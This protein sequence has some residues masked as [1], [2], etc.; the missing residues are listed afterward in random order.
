MLVR[1]SA[2]AAAGRVIDQL[3]KAAVLAYFSGSPLGAHADQPFLN[4][5]PVL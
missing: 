5:V 3:S 4:L 1:A 2:A